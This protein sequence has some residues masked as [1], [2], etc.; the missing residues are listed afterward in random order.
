MTRRQLRYAF[1]GLALVAAAIGV[2]AYLR[3]SP[4]SVTVARAEPNVVIRAFGLGTVEARIVSKIGFEVG[5]ALTE[6]SVDHGD[7]VRKGDILA[8]LHTAEQEA[9]VAK[10][11]AVLLGATVSVR[12][13]EANFEKARAVLAQRQ[14][15]NQRTQGLARRNVASAQAAEETKRDED[16]AAAELAVARSEIEVAKALLAD[17]RAGL[18]FERTILDHHVLAAPYDAIV[19]ERHKE[20]GTVIRAGDSIFT[21]MAPET[22]WVLAHVDESRAGSIREGQAAEVRLRSLPQQTFAARVARIGIE[23]DRVSEERRVWVTCT[24]CPPRIH[25]GEQAEVRITVAALEQALL[26]PEMLVTD[27]DGRTGTAWIVRDGRLDQARLAFR[28]RSDDAR[29]E[30]TSGL[31][32]DAL[33]VTEIV[34][35]LRAG[36]AARII[37][38]RAP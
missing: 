23:S 30:V 6:L 35:G 28:H 1:A 25:L 20:A 9:R 2:V 15:A 26:V 21:L 4:V 22:V 19:V 17:A 5:A 11:E 29:L 7:S 32:S 18:S 36:R 34:P 31:P 3:L 27:F 8:R 14:L 10:A 12:K 16:V 24:D 13:A 38:A 37:E 33:V